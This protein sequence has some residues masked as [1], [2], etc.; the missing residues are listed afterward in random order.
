MIWAALPLLA[1]YV[2]VAALVWVIGGWL[3]G[4]STSGQRLRL[5]AAV[6]WLP[7]L[8]ALAAIGAISA[9]GE[10][11][12]RVFDRVFERAVDDVFDGDRL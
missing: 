6:L 10:W 2:V 3:V 5:I 12:D 11:F 1:S 9:V 7:L 4:L 8:V